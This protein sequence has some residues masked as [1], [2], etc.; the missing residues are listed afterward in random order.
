MQTKS[1]KI[2][3][4]MK[5]RETTTKPLGSWIS[6]LFSGL[7]SMCAHT[8]E[9]IKSFI[10]FKQF[11]FCIHI[12]PM[13]VQKFRVIAINENMS[14]FLHCVKYLLSFH[15]HLN[16]RHFEC[17]CDDS[18]IMILERRNGERKK[19]KKMSDFSSKY[20]HIRYANMLWRAWAV[21]VSCYFLL[22]IL[23]TKI[24][25]SGLFSRA[26]A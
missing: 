2:Q 13:D 21:D 23:K 19:E 20:Q 9:R 4:M 11:I 7:R 1:T 5:R 18:I 14:F 17:V 25:V 15:L 8:N 26:F 6:H 3:K 24:V 22:E 16:E 10:T 12:N